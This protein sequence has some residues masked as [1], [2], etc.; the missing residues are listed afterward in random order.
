M[1]MRTLHCYHAALLLLALAAPAGAHPGGHPGALAGEAF[2]FR[3]SVGPVESGRARMSVGIPVEKNGRRLVAVH[4]QAETLPWL[5]IV[6]K[7]N[8]DYRLVLDADT[9]LPVEVVSIEHG[10]RER[11]IDTAVNGRQVDVSLSSKKESGRSRRRLPEDARDPLSALFAVRAAPLGDGDHLEMLIVD[12]MALWR[13]KI[14]VRRERLRLEN[15]ERSRP[16]VRLDGEN[17]R[18]DDAGKPAPQPPRHYTV[19]LSDDAA[20]VLLRMEAD[21]DLGRAAL[22]L[23]SYQAAR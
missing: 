12:G 7:M 22:E 18:L 10:L 11:R 15:E 8:D 17:Q 16:A 2:T 23:T 3:F 13:S 9:L 21:T 14:Q 19:W 6:A 5:S 20:R 4:G 1:P